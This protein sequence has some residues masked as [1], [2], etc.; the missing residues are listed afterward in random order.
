M[1]PTDQ[2][3]SRGAL[4][5][6]APWIIGFGLLYAGPLIAAGVIACTSW[7]GLSNASLRWVGLEQFL[8]LADDRM[9]RVALSNSVAYAC[10]NTPF[11]LAAALGLALLIHD[12]R[13]RRVWATLYYA[14][15][16]LSGVATILIWAWLLNPQVGP[17][18]RALRAIMTSVGL[19][20]IRPPW[21]FSAT[22]ARPSLIL[23]NLWYVGA[24][25]LIFLAALTR[26]GRGVHEAAMIDGASRWRRFR[27]ITAPQ[28][29]PAIL[30]NALTLF[31]TS[32]LNFEQAYLLLNWQQDNALLFSTVYMYQTAFER[33]RFAFALA[34]GLALLAMLSLAS[35]AAL[36]L[37]RRFVTYD[38][39]EAA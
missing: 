26:A 23:M 17:V 5:F 7:D 13:R 8:A 2:A 28:L 36:V 21:L 9:F 19:D 24:P 29:A 18:N 1:T 16:L 6:A 20:P 32:M 14:P 11:Q 4:R 39:E 3:E 34:Q 12:A 15:H 35:I 22:W 25:M 27:S 31:I 30:F 38:F 33:H 10:V 37:G